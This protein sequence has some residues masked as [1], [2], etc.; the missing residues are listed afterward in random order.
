M[1][2]AVIA[3]AKIIYET[4]SNSMRYKVISRNPFISETITLQSF[5]CYLWQWRITKY[6]WLIGLHMCRLKQYTVICL[7]NAISK[8]LIHHHLTMRGVL[9]AI[10]CKLAIM[11]RFI[12]VG[13]LFNSIR[14]RHS[15]D[16]FLHVQ[17]PVIRALCEYQ[18]PT[19]HYQLSMF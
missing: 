17:I 9:V 5:T 7:P 3:W 4:N 19:D 6:L 10:M 15:P 16:S 18:L 8:R 13:C 12:I 14:Q 11:R 1:R 2:L